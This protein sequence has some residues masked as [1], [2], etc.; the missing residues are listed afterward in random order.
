MNPTETDLVALVNDQTGGAG[1]DVVFEVSG[2]VSG[3]EMM[4]KLPRTRGRIVVVAIFG[5]PQRVDLFRCFWRELKIS[6]ARVYEREDFEAAIGLAA[7]GSLPFDKL[8][9]GVAPL[10]GL[11]DCMHQ[12]EKGGEVMKLL[13]RCAD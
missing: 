9:T 13:V 7:S 4:T 1:A 10:E 3:T 12:M 2:S 8:I 11:E 5:E 6:G